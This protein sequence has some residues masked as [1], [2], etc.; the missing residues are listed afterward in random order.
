MKRVYFYFS[1]FLLFSHYSYSQNSLLDIEKIFKD[2]KF[3]KALDLVN[4]DI[5]KNGENDQNASLKS[6]ILL[7]VNGDDAWENVQHTISKFPNSSKAYFVRANFYFEMRQMQNSINDFNKAYELCKDD[8]LKYD[9]LI[10]RSG[11]YHHSEQIKNAIDDCEMALKLRPT[12]IDALNNLAGSKFDNGE[13]EE[14]EKILLRMK[15]IDPKYIGVYINL[16][17]QM[18]QLGNYEKAKKYLLEGLQVDEKNSYINNNLGYTEF[19]LG[20]TDQAINYI[21]KSLK[22][23]PQN[24]YAF[25]NLALI[26]LS[27][28]DKEKACENIKKALMFKFSEMYGNEVELLRQKYCL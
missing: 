14:A 13:S 23:N 22:I 26:Y 17:Y 28:S 12:S 8:S 24:S 27:K 7:Y 9:I 3:K 25:R 20:N 10:G 15:E 5:L 18:Q 19:K 2:G 21:N 4:S 6:Q 1:I 16:G 11:V